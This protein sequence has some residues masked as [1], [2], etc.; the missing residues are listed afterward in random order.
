MQPACAQPQP[1]TTGTARNSLQV[2]ER[3]AVLL[4]L[5]WRRRYDAEYP[6]AAVLKAWKTIVLR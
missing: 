3:P 6:E 1:K 2:Y 4:L 5:L